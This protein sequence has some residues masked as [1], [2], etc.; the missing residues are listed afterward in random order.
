MC[1][2]QSNTTTPEEFMRQAIALSKEKMEA[3]FGGPFGAVITQNG[4]IIAE[5]YNQVT[6]ANDPT[7]HAE[8]TAIR[9]ACAA[10][11]TFDLAGCEIYTSC[12]P[13][14]MCLSAI[15]W[16]RLDKMYYANSREDAADIGFDD[17]LIYEEI[18]KPILSRNLPTFRLLEDEAIQPFN[19]WKN[20][21][22]KTP[23]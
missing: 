2:C 18:S 22:D 5:G 12:E 19:D 4:R 9:N 1:D 11:G 8:V 3:G 16:A 17:A 21:T 6:S 20:K 7:A 10:L 13:C 15:Y 14:P 23:Y